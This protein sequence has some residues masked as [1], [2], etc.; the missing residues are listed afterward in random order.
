[1][2]TIR[3]RGYGEVT[4]RAGATL[5]EAAHEAG[6]P[7]GSECGGCCSC[8]TCHVYVTGGDALLSPR[9]DEEIDILELASDVRAESRLGCQAKIVGE[10]VIDVTISPESE[11]AYFLEN[12]KEHAR[13]KKPGTPDE[14]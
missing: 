13:L 4:V 6:A 1:M 8:S 14:S 3:F 9:D 10:G 7:E 12:P 5:L 2:A 11:D